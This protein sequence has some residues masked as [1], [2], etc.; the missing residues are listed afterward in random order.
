VSLSR[1]LHESHTM[2]RADSSLE[3]GKALELV[4]D[5]WLEERRYKDLV[6]A[7]LANWTSGN[8]VDFMRPISEALLRSNEQSLHRSLWARTI[9]RQVASAFNSYAHLR[10]SGPTFEELTQVDFQGFNEF[11]INDYDD[12]GR[13]TSYLMNRLVQSL[14]MWRDELRSKSWGEEEVERLIDQVRALKKPRPL[15]VESLSLHADS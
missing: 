3:S 4:R 1:F 11:D 8:C 14:L 7:V 15:S 2:L 9:N 12:R 13:A 10:A 5:K 6:V